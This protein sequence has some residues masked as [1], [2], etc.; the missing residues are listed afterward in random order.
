MQEIHHL[1][2]KFLQVLYIKT[3]YINLVIV[4]FRRK[5]TTYVIN[6]S[7]SK[8][9]SS[10]IGPAIIPSGGFSVSSIKHTINNRYIKQLEATSDYYLRSL[11]LFKKLRVK[12]LTFV[13]GH[14]PSKC[15]TCHW[16]R[17]F[18]TSFLTS[19]H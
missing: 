18:L 5:H 17:W 2:N 15:W 1:R 10:L 16:N 13:F 12:V 19:T 3:Y 11:L 14:K 8:K 6:A 7:H 9:F 4:K